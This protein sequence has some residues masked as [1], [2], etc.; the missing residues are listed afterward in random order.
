MSKEK[1]KGT[2]F[3][4]LVTKKLLMSGIAAERIPLSGSLGGKYDSDV[5]I[6]TPDDP[7]AKIECKN[8]ENIAKTT[9]EWLEGNDYLAIKRNNFIPLVVMTLDEFIRLKKLDEDNIIIATGDQDE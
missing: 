2:R 7:K 1:Q 8:R 4:N 9:W 6:G 3:E 5:I